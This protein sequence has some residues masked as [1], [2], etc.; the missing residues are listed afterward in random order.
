METILALGHQNNWF[1]FPMI[2]FT[3]REKIL[4]YC[5]ILHIINIYIFQ[6]LPLP[7]K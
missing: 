2:Q 6:P 5:N 3:V 1:D 7:Q 4:I